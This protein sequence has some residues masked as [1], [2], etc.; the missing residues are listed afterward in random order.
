MSCKAAE[1]PEKYIQMVYARIVGECSRMVRFPSQFWEQPAGSESEQEPA[2]PSIPGKPLTTAT[3]TAHR[4]PKRHR[5]RF[6]YPAST[7]P[8]PVQ[9]LVTSKRTPAPASS[10]VPLILECRNTSQGIISITLRKSICY[11]TVCEPA[12]KS[13]SSKG[14]EMDTAEDGPVT[15]RW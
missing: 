12:P 8:N 7:S 11:V 10:S 14:E 4:P 9:R 15:A 2:P 1:R 13:A 6:R 5:T 3:A